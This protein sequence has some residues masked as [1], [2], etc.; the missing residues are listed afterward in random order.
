MKNINP[1]FWHAP[2][3]EAFV[4]KAT[5]GC[6]YNQC[7]FCSLYSEKTFTVVPFDEIKESLSRVPPGEAKLVPSVFLGEGN[8]LAAG[9]THLKRVLALASKTFPDLRRIGLTATVHDVLKKRTQYLKDLREA[10]LTVVFMGIESGDGTCLEIMN[11]GFDPEMAVKAGRRI[12][13]AGLYLSVSI[14]LG[15]GGRWGKKA[16]IERTAEILKAINPHVVAIYTLSLMPGT[17]LFDLVKKGKFTHPTPI[18]SAIELRQLIGQL[19]L[20]ETVIHST[21]HSNAVHV[22]G[23][24]PEDKNNLIHALDR[25]LNNPTDEFLTTD[26]FLRG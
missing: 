4:I 19:D 13:D 9:V 22:A 17:P 14:L 16:H 24:L 6:D 8:A 26:Y 3:E 18:E 25:A 11:K 12:I 1:S 21:H 7:S 15:A 5:R 23:R 20:Q 2:D 10:G